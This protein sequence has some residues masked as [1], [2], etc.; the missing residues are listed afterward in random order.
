VRAPVR[1]YHL[2]AG[3]VAAAPVLPT[4]VEWRCAGLWWPADRSW[5]VA[6]DIDGYSTF[7]GGS[8][9]AVDVVMAEPALDAVGVQP[10]TPL[11]PS[12]G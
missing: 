12:Y 1:A 9:A 4:P 10:S 2:P 8:H 5:L 11:D 3:P 6:T 7:V